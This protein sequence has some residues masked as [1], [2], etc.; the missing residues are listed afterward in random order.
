MLR[1]A[2]RYGVP[3]EELIVHNGIINP[4][5]LPVGQVLCIPPG[6]LDSLP[7]AD[8]SL[9][10]TWVRPADGMVMVYVPAGEFEMGSTEGDSDEQPVHTV[11][12][13][14][15][16]IDQTEV[17]NGQYRQ[18]VEAGDCDPPSSSSSSTRDSYYGDSTY[19][20]YPVIRVSWHQA[21]AYCEWAGARLPTEAE[22]EYAA[23]GPNGLIYPW[24]NSAPNDT[25]L[26][27]NYNV[28]DTT[29]TGSYLNGASW[30]NA[31]DM[32][33]NV[34]EWVA[35]WYGDYPSGRQVNPTG[36]SS[37]GQRVLRGGSWDMGAHYVRSATRN[38]NAPYITGYDDPG[39]R[40]ASGSE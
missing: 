2:S 3:A 21:N 32:A 36:S 17:T 40:C 5:T 29:E 28:G 25:L 4:N 12:L 20:D 31:L 37:G 18:C 8:T 14:G 39:F 13:D 33:G 6:G 7:P 16:W 9:G 11:A 38:G 30:C 35:D 23:R 27:Y 15:F 19:H 26:N 34:W 24:G 1:I 22:W 10:D